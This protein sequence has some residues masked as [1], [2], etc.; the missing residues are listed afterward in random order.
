MRADAVRHFLLAIQFFTRIPMI[1]S[2]AK[3]VGYSPAM[4][5]ASVAHLPGVGWVVGAFAALTL[6][7]SLLLLPDLP[8]SL[9]VATLL[10][11]VMSALLTGALHEDGLADTADGLG[12]GGTPERALE[13]MKDSRVGTYGVMALVLALAIKQSLVVLLLEIDFALALV[14]LFV[15]HVASRWMPL[16]LMCFMTYVGDAGQSKSKALTHTMPLT[17]MSLGCAW[18][19]LAVLLVRDVLPMEVFWA[20]LFGASCMTAGLAWRLQRRLNGY[21]GDGLGAVQQV[22]ELGFY[23]GLI[24]ATGAV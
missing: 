14:G 2:L 1:A 22:S 23:L 24:L 5:Q 15:A 18:L 20:G 16:F 19:A 12:G 10:S 6:W 8:A 11:T 3:W 4:M 13:I 17:R 21:T 9:W 7:C